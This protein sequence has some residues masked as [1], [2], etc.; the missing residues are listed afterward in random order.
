MDSFLPFLPCDS[1]LSSLYAAN[2]ATHLVLKLSALKYNEAETEKDALRQ[3]AYLL[4]SQVVPFLP[5]CNVIPICVNPLRTESEVAKSRLAL[6]S[7]R[8]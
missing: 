4:T 5:S 7:D 1:N 6:A 2:A 8:N 3:T